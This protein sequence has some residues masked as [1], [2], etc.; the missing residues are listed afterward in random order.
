MCS[1]HPKKIKYRLDFHK[2][3]YLTLDHILENGISIYDNIY[4]Y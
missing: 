1:V 3:N 2:T 4:I